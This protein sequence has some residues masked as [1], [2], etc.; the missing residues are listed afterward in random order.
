MKHR[1][2]PAILSGGSGTRLWPDSTD[3]RPKQFHALAGGKAL[4]EETAL[5]VQGETAAL[6]F[7]APIILCNEAHAPLVD[8]HMAA[9]S[10]TPSAIVSEPLGRNTA[11][12]AVIAAA[13]AAEIEPDA[14]ILLLPADHV[15]ADR[16]AFLAAI[17]RAAPLAK[18]R[19]ATFG[20]EPNR[21]E[22]GYGYIKRGEPLA[23]GVFKIDSF[24]EKPD[25][26]TA[27]AYIATGEY[28]WNAGMF[29]FN[30]HVM[31]DEFGASAA[32]R[33]GALASLKAAKREGVHIAL[34][35]A[36]Y[37][38]VP[39]QPLDIAVMEKTS[40]GAIAPCDIGWADIGAWDEIWR[41]GKKDAAGNV[42][43]GRAVAL[44]AENTLVRSSGPKVC[45]AG[46]SDLIVIAT[47]E[48][49]IIV[50]RERAQDVKILREMA[51]KID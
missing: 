8:A 32:I 43:Q 46:V 47:P 28:A 33:D 12:A 30:P 48:A 3:E 23:P 51:T 4:I 35:R 36:L 17:E 29:L 22:T 50:P 49:V 39:S 13:V 9:I 16:S 6:S 38:Q 11:A 44:D 24:R 31:L 5:R 10:L 20:I 27:R 19:I 2:I 41:I 14:L 42:L 37:A 25:A 45:V 34:D 7:A 1:I 21:P 26:D 40:R 15:I 18:D